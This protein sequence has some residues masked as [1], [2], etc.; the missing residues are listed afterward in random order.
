MEV[1][2][3]LKLLADDNRLRLLSLLEREELSV[4][5]LTRVTGLGQ[6]RVSHHLGQ[7][8]QAGVTEDRKEGSFNFSRFRPGAP[9][10]PLSRAMWEQIRVPFRITKIAEEDRARLSAMLEERRG[11]PHDR[12]AGGWSGV[13]ESLERGSLRSEA[14]AAVAPR[15]WV[16]ADLGCGAGFLTRLLG[17]RFDRVIG[18]DHSAAML[19]AAQGSVPRG[20]PFE[21]RQGE[22]ESL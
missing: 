3:L 9:G 19:E 4:Q 21:W 15:G 11:G 14:L 1:L 5:E 6:S 7:L 2:P 17:E 18:V 22:L 8:R 10:S 16:V 13:G 12:R 20:A